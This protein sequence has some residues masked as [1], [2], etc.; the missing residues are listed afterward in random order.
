LFRNLQ[1]FNLLKKAYIDSRYKL[2]YSIASNDLEKL[3]A[4]V[5]RLREIME[6]S[7]RDKM[8]SMR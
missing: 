1:L 7:C 2:E 4:S 5:A 6:I 3:S 8:D